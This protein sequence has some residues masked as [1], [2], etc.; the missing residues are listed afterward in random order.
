[1]GWSCRMEA[2]TVVDAWT[3][4]CRAS[5]GQSNVYLGNDGKRYFFEDD[6]VEHDDGA[7]TGTVMQMVTETSCVPGGSFRVEGNGEVAHA[8]SWLLG[9]ARNFTS[10]RRVME[11]RG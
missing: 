7:I 2:G 10:A 8:P 6:S 1:M 11:D 5:T 3:K 4:A 9:V